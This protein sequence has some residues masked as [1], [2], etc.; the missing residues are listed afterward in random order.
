MCIIFPC[1]EASEW[2]ESFSCC[3]GCKIHLRCEGKIL[4]DD[5]LPDEYECEQ[6]RTGDGNKIWL[7]EKVKDRKVNLEKKVELLKAKHNNIKMDIERLEEEES[8]IGPRQKKFKESCKKLGI[9]PAIY[10]GGDLE[11]KAVQTFLDSARIEKKN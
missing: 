10:H 8:N 9:N 4:E 1:D 3:K 5:C 7:E 6:C 2:D 11:G